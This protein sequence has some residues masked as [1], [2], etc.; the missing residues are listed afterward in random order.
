[1]ISVRKAGDRFHTDI[2]WLD[3]RHT[4]SFGDHHDPAFMGFRVL[5]VINEDR[6]APGGGFPTHGHRDMEIL[7]YVLDG[8]LQHR[9]SMG[10]GS[11][12]KP[13]DLQRMSAGKG[14]MHSEENASS[15]A[16][17]HFLQIW[18]QPEKRAADP[19][20]EQ[21]A[22]PAEERKGKLRLIG[23]RDGRQ[24]SVTIH[25]DADLHAALLGSG[26]KA[27]LALREGRHAW[28]QVARG[29]LE[30]NGQALGPG[31][32]AALTGEK[33]VELVGKEAAEVLVFD[34]P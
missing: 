21:K 28:V 20:Y 7:S 16:P 1:M 5:R 3:S 17:V 8:A 32:G 30:L 11:V 19:G 26:E 18:I 29:R 14:V 2:G 15:A 34:L 6:V 10:T 31:D 4:F 9:D 12:I 25:Q 13:G 33:A 23:S 22:F 27:S 24:G